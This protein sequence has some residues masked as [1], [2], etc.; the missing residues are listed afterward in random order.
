MNESLRYKAAVCVE[1][2]SD[3]NVV[4]AVIPLRYL[5]STMLL[6][7]LLKLLLLLV[8]GCGL[9]GNLLVVMLGLVW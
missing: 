5:E 2:S 8:D 3:E 7:G 4:F 6:R 9:G 1:S